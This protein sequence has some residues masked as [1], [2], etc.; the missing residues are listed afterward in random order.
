MILDNGFTTSHQHGIPKF[1]RRLILLLIF[2]TA[3]S[4]PETFIPKLTGTIPIHAPDV[5]SA[6]S[7]IEISIG[8]VNV[9]N[10][11]P[12]GL[13]MVGV[14]GPKVYNTVFTDGQ[15]YFKIPSSDTYQ[16]GYVALIVASED[17]RGEASIIVFSP[18][19]SNA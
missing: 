15:A 14:H 17:A 18:K 3:C 7:P 6:G 12:I 9:A 16:P 5:A 19:Q 13:V 4:A 11:T 2:I 8:P 1:F 10:G